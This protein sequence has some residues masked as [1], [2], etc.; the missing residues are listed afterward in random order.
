MSGFFFVLVILIIYFFLQ[1]R[2][3]IILF[4]LVLYDVPSF[5]LYTYMNDR[6]HSAYLLYFL[7]ISLLYSDENYVKREKKKKKISDQ[8]IKRIYIQE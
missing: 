6:T 4:I 8:H 3:C 1:Q 2:T 5:S 7:Y